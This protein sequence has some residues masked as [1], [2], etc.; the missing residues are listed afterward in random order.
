VLQHTVWYEFTRVWGNPV[1]VYTSPPWS[2]MHPADT[3]P[4]SYFLHWWSVYLPSD[5]FPAGF[6]TKVLY[7]FLT[8]PLHATQPLLTLGLHTQILFDVVCKSCNSSLYHFLSLLLPPLWVQL[9]FSK[10]HFQMSSI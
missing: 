3:F 2:Q 1:V 9:S 5:L 6:V 8:F 10:S 4:P 7:A